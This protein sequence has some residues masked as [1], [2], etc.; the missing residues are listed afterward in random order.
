MGKIGGSTMKRLFR[1]V[2]ILTI[3]MILFSGNLCLA[4]DWD[5]RPVKIKVIDAMTRQPLHGIKVYYVL[6][7]WYPDMSCFGYFF[8]PS[9]IHDA[10]RKLKVYEKQDFLTNENGEVFINAKA[11]SLKCYEN[12]LWEKIVVNLEIVLEDWREEL[13]EGKYG[14][15]SHWMYVDGE[16]G[17][18]NINPA[19]KGFFLTYV[20][21]SDDHE[22]ELKRR[23]Y[24]WEKYQ[25]HTLNKLDDLQIATVWKGPPEEYTVELRRAEK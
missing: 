20:Y 25:K 24:Y 16:R 14:F 9:F 21:K 19:Y 3:V 4:G 13:Y 12:V 22:E 15:V 18:F 7:T 2:L 23:Y 8:Y 5:V 11:L 1:H 6:T 17:L 10:P